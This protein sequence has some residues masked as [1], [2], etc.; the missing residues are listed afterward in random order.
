MSAAFAPVS[1]QATQVAQSHSHEDTPPPTPRRTPDS[2]QNTGIRRK[3]RNGNTDVVVNTDQL[4]LVRGEFAGGALERQED[5]MRLGADTDRGRA[6]LDGLEGVLDL[7]ELALRRL[8]W[9]RYVYGRGG[10]GWS[11]RC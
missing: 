3:T 2:P 6:L 9:V 5:R 10:L 4:L 11:T 7:V 1:S 8:R